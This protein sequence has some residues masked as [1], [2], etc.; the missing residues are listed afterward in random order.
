MDRLQNLQFYTFSP[1]NKEAKNYNIAYKRAA[2]AQSEINELK[3]SSNASKAKFEQLEK[4]LKLWIA[5]AK[6][7][8]VDA[9]REDAKL[10]NEQKQN[11][12]GSRIN[13]LA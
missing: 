13:F 1:R 4:E 12:L 5:K 3:H 2:K 8:S 6:D 9:K 11:S 7:Y 10:H